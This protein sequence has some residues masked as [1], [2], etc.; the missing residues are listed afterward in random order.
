MKKNIEF[1]KNVFSKNS[2]EKIIDTSFSQLGVPSIQDQVLNT[3]SVNDFFILYDQLF[4]TINELGETNSH[5]YLIQKSSEYIGFEEKNEIIEALQNEIAQLRT[6]L[7]DTQRQL[8]ESQTQTPIS[9][10]EEF[11]NTTNTT[12][13]GIVNGGGY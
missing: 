12:G 10:E 3:P 9:Q 8:I 11:L 1:N 7:L 2:Y 5:E 13:G 4:Y 6:E